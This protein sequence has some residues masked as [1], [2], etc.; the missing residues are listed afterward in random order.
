MLE[1]ISRR[2]ENSTLKTE[3]KQKALDYATTYSDGRVG[4]TAV[5]KYDSDSIYSE[6]IPL[7]SIELFRI[8]NNDMSVEDF[9]RSR[10]IRSKLFSFYDTTA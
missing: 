7:G 2:I 5:E 9:R 4:Y 1:E 3:E 8:I 6:T 10:N